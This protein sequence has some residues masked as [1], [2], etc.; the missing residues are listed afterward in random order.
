ME[1]IVNIPS[2]VGNLEGVFDNCNSEKAVVITHPHP[3]Y[4]G[5]MYNSVV[6]ALARAFRQNQYSTL[7]FNFRGV[8]NSAGTY[9][10]GVGEQADIQAAI[11]FLQQTGIKSIDFAGYSFG[12]WILF[13]CSR[14]GLCPGRIFLVSPPVDFI[15]FDKVDDLPGLTLTVVGEKDEY[16][17]LPNLSSLTKGWS[18]TAPLKII[19]GAD[20]FYSGCTDEVLKIIENHL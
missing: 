12:A 4:G 11:A 20:H 3:L 8:G 19:R 9:D 6:Y 13:N 15:P 1:T 5:D 17:S 10:N 2:E 18:Q 16:A 14:Q 7:R